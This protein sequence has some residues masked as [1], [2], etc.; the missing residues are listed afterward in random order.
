MPMGLT[1]AD[2]KKIATL[3]RLSI[4]DEEAESLASQLGQVVA[5]VEQLGEINTDDV[6]PMAHAI[7]QVNV[8]ADDEAR[9]SCPRDE[10]LQ[11]APSR[12][13]ECYR[14]PPVLGS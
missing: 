4:S 13:D 14:V 7:E 11:N 5:Y 8:L 10:M 1:R 9:D 3:A 12:D 2:V 6:E